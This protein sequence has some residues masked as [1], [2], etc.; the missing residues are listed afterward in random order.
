MFHVSSFMFQETTQKSW[1]RLFLIGLLL[2]A[3]LLRI[4]GLNWD[5]GQHLHPDERFLTMVATAAKLPSSLDQYLN[6][7]ISPLNPQNI[8]FTFFVYGTLPLTFTKILAVLFGFDSYERFVLLGRIVSTFFDIG[9]LMFV[10]K[11]TKLFDKRHMID[12]RLK[13]VAIFLYAIF[14]LPI[15]LSHFFA[16]DTFLVFFLTGALFFVLKYFYDQKFLY[17]AFAGL[18]T[19]CAIA[20]KISAVYSIPLFITLI[21]STHQQTIKK[22]PVTAIPVIFRSLAVFA[23]VAYI[24][25]RLGSPYM[26]ATD[27]FLNP[28]PHPQFLANIRQ[29]EGLNDP[30]SFFPPGIQWISKIPV[31]FAGQNIV[32]FGVG[33]P[34]AFLFVWGGWIIVRKKYRE[35][36]IIVAW[37]I[38]FFLY[39]STQYVKAMRYFYVLYPLIA[40][41]ASLGFIDV[42]DRMKKPILRI[43]LLVLIMFWPVSFMAIY[44]RPHSR[45]SASKWIY[46]NIPM[47]SVLAEE[48]WDDPLPLLFPNQPV[49]AY[50]VR[51]LPVF[52]PDT[53]EKWAI[54]NKQL[55]E[56]DYIIFTSNRGYGSIGTVPQKYPRMSQFYKDLFNGKTQFKKIKEFTSYPEFSI[57]KLHFPIPDQWSEEAFTVYDH[58]KVT[59][60]SRE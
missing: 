21:I 19:G 33:I 10:F 37:M 17:S 29:L 11:T 58:P 51:Q 24:A 52:D 31:L 2:L 44:T 39:E 28:L 20:C 1:K 57:F 38:L 43:V 49:G 26:F 34:I 35:V 46:Q 45:V 22:H 60:F 53:P 36:S 48:H 50:D 54:I 7:A 12:E 18:F 42:W 47:H 41:V 3:F 59:I 5:Q 16:V 32:F 30:A 15:Q 40:I 25:L 55:A 27:S 23:F 56:A 9:T 4:Y 14:V 8:G 13:Y 6:P